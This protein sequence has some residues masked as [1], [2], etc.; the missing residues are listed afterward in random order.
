MREGK[1]GKAHS[2]HINASEQP[3]GVEEEHY[4]DAVFFTE[5][6]TGETPRTGKI[7][8]VKLPKWESIR[9]VGAAPESSGQKRSA[10]PQVLRSRLLRCGKAVR[11][12]TTYDRSWRPGF[13]PWEDGP[14]TDKCD[15]DESQ[16]KLVETPEPASECVQD[17]PESPVFISDTMI[18]MAS[19]DAEKT[20]FRTPWGNFFDMVMPFGLKNAG[21]TYQRAMT[22]VFHDMLHHEMEVY[23]DDLVVKSTKANRHLCDLEKAWLLILYTGLA[24]REN[25]LRVNG[26]DICPCVDKT[27]LLRYG[28][29]T[30]Q[31]HLGDPEAGWENGRCLGR[32]CW[33]RR[34]TMVVGTHSIH[35][36]S[37]L[38][39]TNACFGDYARKRSY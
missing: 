12:F 1:V 34:S 35:I 13:I 8:G 4:S 36:T 38:S 2:N 3:F 14:E 23:V 5:L 31:S 19:E 21:A 15:D 7:A 24:L 9:E 37:D 32:N 10:T 16:E 17:R 30:Y 11:Q 22:A 28:H 25:I 20:A 18:K 26:S 39:C 33:S 27:S 29:G 6:S